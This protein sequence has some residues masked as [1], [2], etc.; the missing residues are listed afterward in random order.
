MMA[1]ISLNSVRCLDNL[2]KRLEHGRASPS[3]LPLSTEVIMRARQQGGEDSCRVHMTLGPVIHPTARI[4]T[5]G[6]TM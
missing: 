2:G 6:C 4:L 3:S 5:S 1:L